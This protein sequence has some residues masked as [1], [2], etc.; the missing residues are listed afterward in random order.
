MKWTFSIGFAVAFLF[1]AVQTNAATLYMDPNTTELNRGDTLKISVRLDT[2]P[3]ECVNVIDGVITYSDNIQVVDISRGASIM[4]MWVEEPV[5]DASNHTITFAGGIP[6]GYCGRIAG[7]PR[8]TNV[9]IDLLVQSPGF[10]IGSSNDTNEGVI[11]FSEQ[12]Q[13][14]LNDG[15]GTRA[16]TALYGATVALSKNAGPAEN[17]AAHKT[18]LSYR[19]EGEF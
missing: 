15:L 12:T 11:A 14:L 10:V 16:D 1:F 13:I 9:L 17:G 18:G 7:D 6:N 8:L 4:S 3:D 19:G 2:D 5:I